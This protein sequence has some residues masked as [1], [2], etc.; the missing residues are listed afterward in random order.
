MHLSVML[1]YIGVP[2]EVGIQRS[3]FIIYYP[4]LYFLLLFLPSSFIPLH[5]RTG[6]FY[7]YKCHFRRVYKLSVVLIAHLD[8]ISTTTCSSA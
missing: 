3:F 7:L 2:V 4:P 1:S 5:P 8:F 6:H